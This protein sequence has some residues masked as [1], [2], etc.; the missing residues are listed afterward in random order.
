[1]KTPAVDGRPTETAK[2]KKNVVLSS[3]SFPL[4]LSPL[5]LSFTLKK[6]VTGEIKKM[7]NEKKIDRLG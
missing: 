1:M 4:Y 2:N 5:S 7:K 3:L 6:C